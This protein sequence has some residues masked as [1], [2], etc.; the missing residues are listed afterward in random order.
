[1]GR[2]AERARAGCGQERNEES[3]AEEERGAARDC[4]RTSVSM[5]GKKQARKERGR[6]R[7]RRREPVKSGGK[8]PAWKMEGEAE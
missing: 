7:E 1:M 5:R 2:A 4:L 3:K 8:K 6:Q